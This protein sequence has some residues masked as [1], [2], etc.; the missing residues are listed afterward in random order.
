M[1]RCYFCQKNKQ[2]D[3]KDVETLKIF[4]SGQMKIYPRKKT[5]LCNSH[6]RQLKTAIKRARVLGLLPF[7]VN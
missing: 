4:I 3:Y 6:Q 2:V 7:T 1:N 5:G